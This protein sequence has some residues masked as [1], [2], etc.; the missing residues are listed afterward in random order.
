MAQFVSDYIHN[1]FP[2]KIFKSLAAVTLCTVHLKFAY[3]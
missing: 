2:Q 1:M 3:I